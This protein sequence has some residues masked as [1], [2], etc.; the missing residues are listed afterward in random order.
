MASQAAGL[1]VVVALL[2]L[3]AAT[4][5][6]QIAQAPT[7]VSETLELAPRAPP[8]AS[9]SAGVGCSSPEVYGIALPGEGPD[10]TQ[11]AYTSPSS[12]AVGCPTLFRGTVPGAFNVTGDT[13]VHL[14]VG[15]DEPTVMH[16]PLN[17]LRVWLVRN[18][19]AIGEG[20]NSFPTTCSPDSPMELEVEIPRP[21]SPHFNAS[22]M[23]GLNVTPFGSPNLLVD[24][25]H[26]LLGGNETASTATVPGIEEALSAP[27]TVEDSVEQANETNATNTSIEPTA[28]PDAGDQDGIPGFGVTLTMMLF[29]GCAAWTRRR[30]PR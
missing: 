16:Q 21:D 4:V 14:F 7:Q 12:A 30:L 26:V 17:N 20:R 10:R 11:K 27:K 23:L 28:T 15:C 6:G 2:G 1:A 3:P 29:A 5:A 9:G 8:Q 19:Q 13:T 18:G 25:L 24:N 22:D